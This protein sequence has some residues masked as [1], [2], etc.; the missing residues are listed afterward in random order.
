MA[1]KPIALFV[2][3]ERSR[4]GFAF[5]HETAVAAEQ[6]LREPTLVEQQDR[7]LAFV[8]RFIERILECLREHLAIA[9]AELARHIDHLDIR[10]RLAIGAACHDHLM[11]RIVG[12]RPMERLDRGRGRTQDERGAIPAHEPFCHI[13]RHI[14]RRLVL[15]IAAF[16]LFVDDDHT[17]VRKRSEERAARTHHHTDLA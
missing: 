13:T 3:G 5:R 11:P 4:T 8:E 14:A 15:L 9:R 7:F 10:Q 12:L 2:I 1:N 6:E 17:H 16:V